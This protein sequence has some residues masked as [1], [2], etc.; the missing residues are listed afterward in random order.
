MPTTL[1]KQA[2]LRDKLN[3]FVL[4]TY[5]QTGLTKTSNDK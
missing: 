5:Y 4:S 2:Q 1:N 3:N